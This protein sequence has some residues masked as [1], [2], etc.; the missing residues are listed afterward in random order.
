MSPAPASAPDRATRAAALAGA[1]YLLALAA[2]PWI[3]SAAA[4]VLA[5]LS[6]GLLLWGGVHAAGEAA[7]RLAGWVPAHLAIIATGGLESPL[8]AV[9]AL[10][11][12]WVAASE[13]RTGWL[14]AAGGGALVLVAAWIRA[15]PATPG[16]WIGLLLVLALGA[17]LPRVLGTRGTAGGAPPQAAAA[18]RGVSGG[19][20]QVRAPEPLARREA[21]DLALEL[22][23][24]ATDAHEAAL[25]AADPDGR[26]ARLIG[27]AGLPEH[28]PPASPTP[29]EGH[30]FGW[31][32]LEE[33]H[34]HLERGRRTLPSAWASEMLLVPVAVPEGVLALAYA[35]AAPPGV[36]GTALSA[37]RSLAE[38]LSLLRVREA[39]ERTEAQMRTLREITRSLPGELEMDRFVEL[40][41]GAACDSTGAVGVAVAVWDAETASGRVL[42]RADAAGGSDRAPA[43]FR[44]SESRLALAMKHGVALH[45]A[46]LRRELDALPLCLAQE[47]WAAAPRSAMVVPMM[48]GP[49]AIGGVAV[50][51]PDPDR[52]DER[53]A[54]FLGILCALA[55]PPLQSAQ[56]YAAL[57]RRA[58]S[59]ALTGLPNRGAFETRLASVAHHFERYERPFA[60]VILDVDHFKKFNDTWGHEAGDRVLQ[61][62][63]D[64]LRNG[65]REV[66]LPA[67]LGGEEFV[68][69][70]PET[71][72]ADAMEA[73]ERVRRAIESRP[74]TWN[75]KP[76]RVTASFGVAACPQCC[77]LPGEVLAAADAALYRSKDG[78]RNRVTAAPCPDFAGA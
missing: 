44:E 30:P 74:V 75:G 69:L 31:A 73:A 37:S 57:D 60:L 46:D 43:P 29:L 56:K 51:H 34:V 28:R 41:A 22:V 66:D 10:A 8:L 3:G 71:Q 68:I 70:L 12:A 62:V 50:W 38:L 40:L 16:D 7:L 20:R 25:W 33:V 53:D 54:E 77:P 1:L 47:R 49:A 58:S 65:V 36:E 11:I 19:A 61:H 18:R 59:D 9:A 4:L 23:R 13:E 39:S 76:L 32:I 17:A 24:S 14:A 26:E 45:Y 5:A 2:L 78:G 63:A 52:F 15:E 6:A 21:L 67:R 64:L 42:L 72:L 48:S 35:G 27:W 55:A